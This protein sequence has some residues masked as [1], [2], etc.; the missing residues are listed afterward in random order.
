M[1][2]I[3]KT[4]RSSEPNLSQ[5]QD[6][7]ELVKDLF[8]PKAAIFWSDLL[9]SAT[10]GWVAS[11]I[12]CLEKPFSVVQG[13]S[14]LIAAIAFYRALVFIHELTHLK[15]KA[16]PGFAWV[17]NLAVGIPLL[18]PSFTY[19]GV[20][21][22]HHRLSTYGTERDPE[23]MPFAGKKGAILFFVGHSLLLPGLLALRFLVLSPLGLLF[24]FFHR[25]LERHASSLSM[26][27]AYCREVS[28]AER[29]QMKRMELLLLSIWSIPLGL[30][31]AQILPWRVFVIW[32]A[33]MALIML[34]NSLRT[35][36][37][38]RYRSDGTP[39]NLIDQFLDSIDTPGFWTVLW[40]PVGLRYHALH[41]Y[42][43]S[44][45]Y[46]NL[47]IARARLMQNLPPDAPYHQT[48]S[49][50]LGDSLKQLWNDRPEV[51]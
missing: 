7:R 11:I 6:Y 29:S 46:H 28:T 43:P 34:T 15:E 38:H 40:S 9:L 21:A 23:Y 5:H 1:D 25:G 16:L 2:V 30:A 36:G 18:L 24:P 48:T 45:P 41:H 32:Y 50:S 8:V 14:I 26:N 4:T 10:V 12:A 17:W 33:I 39:M 44:M 3:S 42:F 19:T 20:H 31:G 47:P 27:V 51:S 22:E 35:L 37:A 49:P 13:V